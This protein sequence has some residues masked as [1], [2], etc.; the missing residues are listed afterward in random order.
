MNAFI[1]GNDQ[2]NEYDRNLW[3]NQRKLIRN[4]KNVRRVFSISL[5]T[6]CKNISIGGRKIIFL[7]FH[8]L[9]LSIFY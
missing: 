9:S 5:N 4:K 3:K 2:L 7:P 6:K 1:H 8:S